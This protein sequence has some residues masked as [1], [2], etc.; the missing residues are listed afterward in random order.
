MAREIGWQETKLLFFAVESTQNDQNRVSEDWERVGRGSGPYDVT[1]RAECLSLWSLSSVWAMKLTFS[2]LIFDIQ[3]KLPTTEENT[4]IQ[5]EAI[6]K[7]CSFWVCRPWIKRKQRQQQSCAKLDGELSCWDWLIFSSTG[8][9]GLEGEASRIEWS[10]L[11]CVNNERLTPP[12]LYF[13][14]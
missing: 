2:L 1:N 12:W 4:K 10:V 6:S 7:M 11:L 5:L 3:W 13:F 9:T 14:C 8:L